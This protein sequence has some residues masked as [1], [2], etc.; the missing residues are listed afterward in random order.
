[1][2]NGDEIGLPSPHLLDLSQKHWEYKYISKPVDEVL[3]DTTSQTVYSE[4]DSCAE[5]DRLRPGSPPT[6][7]DSEEE[8]EG[9]GGQ[10]CKGNGRKREMRL[11]THMTKVNG[12][13]RTKLSSSSGNACSISNVTVEP[14]MTCSSTTPLNV[15]RAEAQGEVEG[16]K[17]DGVWDIFVL[18]LQTSGLQHISSRTGYGLDLTTLL[19]ADP[20][21][22]FM[23]VTLWRRAAQLGAKI[24]RA[25]DLVRLNRCDVISFVH[26]RICPIKGLPL[27]HLLADTC[28]LSF[29]LEPFFSS[30]DCICHGATESYVCLLRVPEEAVLGSCSWKC[31]FSYVTYI[32]ARSGSW[33]EFTS[34]FSGFQRSMSSAWN[35]KHGN[36]A[37]MQLTFARSSSG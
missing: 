32:I 22:S 7:Q 19:I 13:K 24:I 33:R 15:L 2:K 12:V 25:G 31:C 10:E 6:K 1:M 23:R 36:V 5:A 8:K 20:T 18:I 37:T 16:K 29:H 4:D 14:R 21:S 3:M 28:S 9:S 11:H 35:P 17:H 27:A 30:I 26:S 34:W